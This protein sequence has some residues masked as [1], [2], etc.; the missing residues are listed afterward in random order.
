MNPA[1]G[2]DALVPHDMLH[3]LV[4]QELGLQHGIFGQIARGGTAGTFH[5]ASGVSK[6]R[7][8]SRLRRKTD[9]RGKK[10]LK[11][12]TDDCAQSERATFICL[13][14]WLVH[15]SDEKLR[16]RAAEM[17]PNLESILGQMPDGER[18]I[19]NKEKLA[20]VRCRMDELSAQWSAL[21]VNQ[22]MTLEWSA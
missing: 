13:H 22:S 3:F 4:E 7:A 10:L 16:A 9:R 14:D 5:Q 2:F 19:L 12:N 20:R 8:D 17:K 18:K 21:G 11:A 6:S 1:P 15:S